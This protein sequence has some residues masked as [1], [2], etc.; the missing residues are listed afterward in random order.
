MSEREKVR[1]W[2]DTYYMD[3][4]DKRQAKECICN[5]IDSIIEELKYLLNHLK[6][7]N[8]TKLDIKERIEYW[9]RVKSIAEKI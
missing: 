6:I 2:C 1:Q 3:G 5:S 8:G 7:F 4:F 9:N